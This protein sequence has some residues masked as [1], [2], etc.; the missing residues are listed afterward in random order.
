MK[1]EREK[2]FFLCFERTVNLN[3]V[4]TKNKQILLQW[5]M[6]NFLEENGKEIGFK[7][8]LPRITFKDKKLIKKASS[9]EL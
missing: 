5:M 9:K 6:K 8:K 4:Y 7:R 3:I 1:Q 2:V